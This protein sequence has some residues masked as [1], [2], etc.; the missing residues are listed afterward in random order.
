MLNPGFEP[1][2]VPKGRRFSLCFC[3]FIYIL[4]KTHNYIVI[5]NII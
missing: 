2:R 1:G 3:N 5:L 4:S